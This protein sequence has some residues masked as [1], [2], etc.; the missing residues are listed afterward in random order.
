[1]RKNIKVNELPSP[2]WRWLKLNESWIEDMESLNEKEASYYLPKDVEI[3]KT[4]RKS[5]SNIETALGKDM[6]MVIDDA[7][8][9]AKTIVVNSKVMGPL[10]IDIDYLSDDRAA[11]S[12]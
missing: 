11:N 10:R 12:L 1:M 4:P 7:T 9:N 3:S 8:E 6:E 5:I 2:T